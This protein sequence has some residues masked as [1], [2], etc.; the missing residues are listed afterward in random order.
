MHPRPAPPVSSH[1]SS[2]LREPG[3]HEY[4]AWSAPLATPSPAVQRQDFA[5][6]IIPRRGPASL[7][8]EG[9]DQE[10]ETP[11]GRKRSLTTPFQAQ[12]LRAF[13]TI[14]RFPATALRDEVGQAIGLSGRQVQVRASPAFWNPTLTFSCD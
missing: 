13:I 12:V 2:A 11:S 7:D 10:E 14:T 4:G 3:Y 1:L 5:L 8:N 6:P 9:S